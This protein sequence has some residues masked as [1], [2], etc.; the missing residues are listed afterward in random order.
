MALKNGETHIAPIHLL[1]M[2]SGE[3][4]VS[5]IKKYIGNRPMALIKCVKEFKE[6]WFLKEILIILLLLGI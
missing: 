3:Y 4:N 5:Y 1:D 6:L 2:E